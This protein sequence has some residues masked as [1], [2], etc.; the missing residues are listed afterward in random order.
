M[1]IQ[2]DA[3]TDAKRARNGQERERP[4]RG[5]GAATLSSGK[6]S[7]FRPNG[8]HLLQ[9]PCLTIIPTGIGLSIS[10]RIQ[11]CSREDVWRVWNRSA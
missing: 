2:R 11:F 1:L 8:N 9:C 7:L 4:S 6:P 3:L 5:W 10:L